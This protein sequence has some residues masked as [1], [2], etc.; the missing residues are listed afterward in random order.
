MPTSNR[1][2]VIALT[3]GA[4]LSTQAHE[5]AANTDSPADNDLVTLTSGFNLLTP[6]T[7][8]STPTG[9][10]IIPPVGNVESITLKGITGDTG[11]LLHPTDPSSFGLGSP[12]GTFGLTVSD[13]IEGVR[14]VW[15]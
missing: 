10:T 14:I 6:P 7:G 11:V 1:R 4:N 13:D 5:A 15:T 2:I 8:G 9:V 12:T 3:E